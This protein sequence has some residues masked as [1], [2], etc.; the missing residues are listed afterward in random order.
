MRVKPQAHPRSHRPRRRLG[1]ATKCNQM[2]LNFKV[3]PL[4][5]TPDEANQ[6]HNQGGFTPPPSFPCRW[7]IPSPSGRGLG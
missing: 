1:N 6:G 5:A 7:G 2:Q 4:L 3:S